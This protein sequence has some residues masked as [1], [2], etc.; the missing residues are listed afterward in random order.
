MILH[1]EYSISA[2]LLLAKAASRHLILPDHGCIELNSSLLKQS[3]VQQL[4]A[5]LLLS[6][7]CPAPAVCVGCGLTWGLTTEGKGQRLVLDTVKKK[8]LEL[9]ESANPLLNIT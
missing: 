2:W 8:D 6:A 3:V 4:L 1:V 9:I 7:V 5:S